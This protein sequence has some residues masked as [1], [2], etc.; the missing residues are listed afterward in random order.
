MTTFLSIHL[1]TASGLKLRNRDH[2]GR[3]KTVNF[4]GDLRQRLSSQSWKRALRS[5]GS[6]V[7]SDLTRRW[8]NRPA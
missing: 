7:T 8:G 2:T 4:R 5:G 1:L 6:T 3:P